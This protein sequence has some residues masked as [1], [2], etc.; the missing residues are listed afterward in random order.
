MEWNQNHQNE[1]DGKQSDSNRETQLPA[2]RGSG[3]VQPILKLP[4]LRTALGAVRKAAPRVHCI[5][6]SVTSESVANLLLTAGG[7]AIM[8]EAV[9]EVEEVTAACQATLLNS[10]VPSDKKWDSLRGAGSAA[11]A[12]NHPLILD[13][14]GAAASAYRKAGLAAL[15][16]EVKPTLIRCNQTEALALLELQT[17]APE[18]LLSGSVDSA[19]TIEQ[20]QLRQAAGLLARRFSCTVLIT[21]ETDLISDGQ[22]VLTVSGGDRRICRLTGGGCMLSALCAL[23]AGAG[24]AAFDA[25]AV[26]AGLW[27]RCAEEAGA[28]TDAAGG[29][30]GTFRSALFDAVDAFAFQNG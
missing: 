7:S 27:K 17:K 21:G 2:E 22:R 14:V 20:G 11:N 1:A 9:Q 28:R 3:E 10:G 29:G 4:D 25:A 18:Q 8:A 5:T 12:L 6:N 16:A 30:M 19:L 15:L 24:L 26:A 13:P 23:F